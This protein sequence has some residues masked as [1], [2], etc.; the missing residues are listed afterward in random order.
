MCMSKYYPQVD[1]S[2]E[3]LRTSVRFR[4]IRKPSSK[5]RVSRYSEQPSMERWGRFFLILIVFAWVIGFVAGFQVA[6]TILT[7]IGFIA[8]VIGLRSPVIGLFGIGMLSV[9]D[10]VNRRFLFGGGGGLL[11]WNTLNYWLLFIAIIYFQFIIGLSDLQ[12][13]ILRVFIALLSLGILVS[14]NISE[15]VQDVFSTVVSFSLVVYFVRAIR[16]EESLYWLGIVNGVLGVVGG[17]V[18]YLQIDILPYIDPNVWAYLPLTALFSLSLAF[19]E[20]H[21]TNRN[22]KI[23]LFMSVINFGWIFLSGSR[24]NMLSGIVCLIYLFTKIQG[25]TWRFVVVVVS[26]ILGFWLTISFAEQQTYVLE[27]FERTFNLDYSLSRRTSTRALIFQAGWDLFLEHPLGVGTGGFKTISSEA[28]I[29]RGESKSPHSA[30]VKTITENGVLGIITLTAFT[31]SFAIVGWQKQEQGLLSLGL[32][33]STSLVLTLVSKV[34]GGVGL[35]FF[36]A[37]GMVILHS[38]NM[39]K[40]FDDY[41]T[42][43]FI[44]KYNLPSKNSRGKKL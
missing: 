21:I 22:T 9:L 43:R 5:F 33:I 35:W 8:A 12:S 37:W 38:E 14:P 30:W 18:F 7:G 28:E 24:G 23:I 27:R 41:S 40:L 34:F 4:R 10:E 42:H 26:V 44:R 3:P 2:Q 31:V 15:G 29:L 19:H 16:E 39:I 13:R 1:S 17:L 20:G 11:R 25:L 32:F 6:L 36:V